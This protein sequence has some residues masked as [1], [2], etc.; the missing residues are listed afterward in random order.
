MGLYVDRVS[1]VVKKGAARFD[2][3]AEVALLLAD[4]LDEVPTKD[5]LKNLTRLVTTV[6]ILDVDYDYTEHGMLRYRHKCDNGCGA[7]IM[8]VSTTDAEDQDVGWKTI[9]DDKGK[10]DFCPQCK[11]LVH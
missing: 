10:K 1:G 7:S 5:E 11:D 6:P 4:E 9:Y 3:L 8:C 2:E